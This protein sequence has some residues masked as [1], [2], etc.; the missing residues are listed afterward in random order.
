MSVLGL[1]SLIIAVLALGG[2]G[3]A[4]VLALQRPVWLREQ[5]RRI[6]LLETEWEEVLQKIKKRG[7]RL[8]RE[9]GILAKAEEE[10]PTPSPA[11]SRRS[12]LWQMKRDKEINRAK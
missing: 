11:A 1:V 10:T 4:V 5:D 3:T 6:L 8:S 9:R 7:D 12:Q 2:A